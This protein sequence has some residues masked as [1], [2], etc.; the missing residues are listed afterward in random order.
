MN[1]N[2]FIEETV[3]E[4]EDKIFRSTSDGGFIMPCTGGNIGTGTQCDWLRSKLT[5]AI[6]YWFEFGVKV[7][8]KSAVEYIKE[9][10]NPLGYGAKSRFE[11]ILLQALEPDKE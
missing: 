8:R 10:W 4:F 3:K 7:G 5:A 2:E 11:K 9:K 1:Q 6:E